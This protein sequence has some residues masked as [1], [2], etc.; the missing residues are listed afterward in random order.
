MRNTGWMKVGGGSHRTVAGS[1]GSMGERKRFPCH[2]KGSYGEGQ[3]PKGGGKNRGIKKRMRKVWMN[4]KIKHLRMITVPQGVS[5]CV[6][7]ALIEGPSWEARDPR[8]LTVFSSSRGEREGH[9][10]DRLAS[11]RSASDSREASL[12]GFPPRSLPLGRSHLRLATL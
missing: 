11:P 6:Q 1:A 3:G 7:L 4:E 2:Q 12:A 8:R 9:G 5:D 10:S